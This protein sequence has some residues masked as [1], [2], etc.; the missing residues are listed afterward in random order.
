[1]RPSRAKASASELASGLIALAA[2]PCA[3]ASSS[4]GRKLLDATYE[5]ANMAAVSAAKNSTG[6]RRP[7]RSATLP[8]PGP[9][10]TRSRDAA[11]RIC[12]IEPADRPRS[13]NH[14]GMKAAIA[15]AAK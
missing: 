1:M 13:A 9:A 14:N 7:I 6:R 3:E 15:L 2:I 12:P 10:S 11:P 8:H 5:A 4:S